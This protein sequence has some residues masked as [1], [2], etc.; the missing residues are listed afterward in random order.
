MK[1]DINQIFHDTLILTDVRLE[2]AFDAARDSIIKWFRYLTN[3]FMITLPIWSNLLLGKHVLSNYCKFIPIILLYTGDLTRHRC[4][5]IQS[6]E[7]VLIMGPQQRTTAINERC[8]GIL[9]RTQLGNTKT[10]LSIYFIENGIFISYYKKIFN[11]IVLRPV[12][13]EETKSIF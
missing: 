7:C 10:L 13:K 3:F 5:I 12:V 2:D 1:T 4:R 9:K 8:M 11:K 6:H